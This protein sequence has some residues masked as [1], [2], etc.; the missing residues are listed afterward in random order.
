MCCNDCRHTRCSNKIYCLPSTSKMWLVSVYQVL[1]NLYHTMMPKQLQI[2]YWVV[3]FF[4][5][6]VQIW[7]KVD[8]HCCVC[9]EVYLYPVE[10]LHNTQHASMTDMVKS[11][12][13]PSTQTWI[14]YKGQVAQG[15]SLISNWHCQR[16]GTLVTNQATIT[17]MG[18]SWQHGIRRWC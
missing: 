17:V 1:L 4:T 5:H 18:S 3:A 2:I 12:D 9:Y 16:E 13:C 8:I 6:T 15:N 7:Y 11:Y 10:S 14:F